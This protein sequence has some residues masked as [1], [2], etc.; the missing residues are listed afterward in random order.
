MTE[1]VDAHK[2]VCISCPVGYTVFC[3]NYLRIT[4]SVLDP[5]Q[6]LAYAKWNNIQPTGPRSASIYLK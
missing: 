4:I 6:S 3:N 2:V 5:V 1:V